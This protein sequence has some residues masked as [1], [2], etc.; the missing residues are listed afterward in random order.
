MFLCIV[1]EVP[2]IIGYSLLPNNIIK[3]L[4]LITTTAIYIHIVVMGF[5]SGCCFYKGTALLMDLRKNVGYRGPSNV[6]HV[7]RRNYFLTDN[8]RVE[9]NETF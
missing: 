2:L 3:H 6:W 7:R 9:V 8:W 5:Y 1:L 4:H